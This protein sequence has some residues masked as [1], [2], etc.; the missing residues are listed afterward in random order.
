MTR[1]KLILW[2]KGSNKLPIY[3]LDLRGGFKRGHHWKDNSTIGKYGTQDRELYH[4]QGLN[5]VARNDCFRL[6]HLIARNCA[7]IAN[8]DTINIRGVKRKSIISTVTY[9]CMQQIQEWKYLCRF[10][11]ITCFN[12]FQ[13]QSIPLPQL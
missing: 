7:I 1:P 8:K 6:H 3:S 2:Y 13:I 9:K 4:C 11:K 12:S 10:L 5:S